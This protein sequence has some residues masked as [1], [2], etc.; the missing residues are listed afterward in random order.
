MHAVAI[1]IVVVKK[2]VW[3]AVMEKYVYIATIINS[4][5]FCCTLN[6][7][8][9]F[10]ISIALIELASSTLTFDFIAIAIAN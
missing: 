9:Q 8:F 4:Y 5:L 7:T 6:L 3:K 10:L 1:A 2:E